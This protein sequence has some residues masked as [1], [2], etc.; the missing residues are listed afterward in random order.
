M[1]DISL[2]AQ[3][4]HYVD[5]LMV[6]FLETRQ[7]TVGLLLACFRLILGIKGSKFSGKG[8]QTAGTRLLSIGHP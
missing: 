3:A 1:R 8:F 7:Q 4:K 5:R 2:F 6:R